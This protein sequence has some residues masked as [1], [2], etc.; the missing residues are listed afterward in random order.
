MNK[1]MCDLRKNKIVIFLVIDKHMNE[2]I[3]LENR[4]NENKTF[5]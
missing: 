3:F 5:L 1:G 2:S 4:Q